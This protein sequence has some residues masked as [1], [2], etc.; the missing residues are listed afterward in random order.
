MPESPVPEI[1]LSIFESL[2]QDTVAFIAHR[3]FMF[4]E[5]FL[6]KK[7]I[8]ISLAVFGALAINLGVFALS[9]I[10]P[11]FPYLNLMVLGNNYPFYLLIVGSTTLTAGFFTLVVRK[12]ELEAIEKNYPAMAKIWEESYNLRCDNNAL[13][14][15]IREL[16]YKLAQ[17]QE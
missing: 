14:K 9:N 16:E 1:K 2:F 12:K 7:V 11:A 10:I 4:K 8:G 15:A 5:K 3:S 17:K 6:N 13:K